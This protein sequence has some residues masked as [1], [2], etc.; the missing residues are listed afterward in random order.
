MSYLES[1][2][3]RLIAQRDGIPEVQVTA[4]YI[5]RQREERFYPHTKYDLGYMRVPGLRFFTRN[6]L[7]KISMLM[8]E[9]LGHI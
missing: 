4:A 5:H 7:E 6:Q 2:F 3:T 9:L 1:L 8:D